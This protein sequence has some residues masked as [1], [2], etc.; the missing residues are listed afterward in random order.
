MISDPETLLQREQEE[1][2]GSSIKCL[3]LYPER[4]LMQSNR[5]SFAG[6]LFYF[7]SDVPLDYRKL[8]ADQR[9]KIVEAVM[10][11]WCWLEHGEKRSKAPEPER[12]ALAHLLAGDIGSDNDPHS[13]RN[14]SITAEQAAGMGTLASYLLRAERHRLD[15][16][17]IGSM[18][19]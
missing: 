4:E 1:L 7:E 9:D 6:P 3:H 17:P 12:Q 11:A 15:Q 2:A 19:R 5:N 8:I 13:H 16:H 10:Q 14:V 18:S